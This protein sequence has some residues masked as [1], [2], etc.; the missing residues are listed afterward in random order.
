MVVI[1]E[2][3]LGPPD[4]DVQLIP[5]SRLEY[6]L[7]HGLQGGLGVPDAR[8]SFDGSAVQITCKQVIWLL[9]LVGRFSAVTKRSSSHSIQRWTKVQRPRD[10]DEE[11][12][13]EGTRGHGAAVKKAHEGLLLFKCSDMTLTVETFSKA[14]LVQLGLRS[15]TITSKL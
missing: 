4:G 13:V 2:F 8:I 14:P 15:F 6:S 10:G 7:T 11:S 9:W 1:A 12:V 5:P 3:P